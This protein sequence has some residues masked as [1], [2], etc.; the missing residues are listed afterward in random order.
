[1]VLALPLTPDTRHLVD[2]RVLAE[3][4]PQA[5]LI[6]VGRGELVDE[7]ALV[8]A[9]RRGDIAGAALDVFTEEPLAADSPLWEMP[10]VII[11][12]HSSANSERSDQRAVR[13]F[14]DNVGR[15]TR[16]EALLNEV[17]PAGDGE[18]RE[19]G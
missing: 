1:M 13:I 18:K 16:G 12:P 11:T 19:V 7:P 8:D 5:R 4:P 9:L 3:M 15:Y 17:A 2:T 6:N 14:I 10:N